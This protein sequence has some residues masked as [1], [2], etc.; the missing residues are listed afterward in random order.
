M[1]NKTITYILLGIAIII[2]SVIALL[3]FKPKKVEYKS[4]E[5]ENYSINK[6][7]IIDTV[8]RLNYKDPFLKDAI[9]KTASEYEDIP[10]RKRQESV[11]QD[12]SGLEIKCFGK[13]KKGRTIYYPTEIN[14]KRH[15]LKRGDIAEGIYLYHVKN[16]T[17]Y[18]IE[19]DNKENKR[20]YTAY[21]G[22]N[23][24]HNDPVGN[25]NISSVN[26]ERFDYQA[27]KSSSFTIK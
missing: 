20:K 2:W 24:R 19:N 22:N 10:S 23:I 21:C 6:L 18:F 14:K 15:I 5:N 12:S 9:N 16:D 17:L 8:L 7:E 25:G 3:F 27:N 13:L 4:R 11:P 1:R 26:T